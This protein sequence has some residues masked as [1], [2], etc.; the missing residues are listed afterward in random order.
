MKHNVSEMFMVPT[1]NI[2]DDLDYIK[3]I[4][5]EDMLSL[6]VHS[7]QNYSKS[8]KLARKVPISFAKPRN[9]IVSGMG[10]SAIG[11]ELLKDW[12]RDRA[13]VA[14]EVCR[15]YSL[16]AYANKETLVFVNSYSGETEET[17]SV[18]LDAV[19][20]NCKIV[21]VSS[22]GKLLEFAERLSL[23]YIRVPSDMPPRAALPF[24]FVPL[25]IV[26]QK[27]GF[28]SKVEKELSDATDVVEQI[29]EVNSPQRSCIENFSKTLASEICG[30]IPVIYGFG[31]YRGVGQ[32][33]KQQFN[34]NS[35]I[36]AKWE[37]FSELN[38]NEIVGWEEAD[39]F[40]RCF[41]IMF[42]RDD[43]ERPEIKLRIETSKE[44]IPEQVKTFEVW[45]KG[46]N[47]LSKM[48][49]VV[50][51]GDFT[52]IYI[53][54]LRGVDPTPVGTISTLKQKLAQGNTRSKT[55]HDLEKISRK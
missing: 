30:T 2:L 6:C 32:R 54:L 51:I 28:V 48:L 10:G 47:T 3:R 55:L 16:P 1:Q 38:H 46:T 49:S 15:D 43:K 13:R 37:Y 19:K 31:V 44:I 14:I 39:E 36:P 23:P 18:L 41:S 7:A 45:S 4:D 27:L 11:G 50:C 40:L 22:G 29:I 33:F 24:M 42:I 34:E 8:M 21:C 53:A 35:K 12:A 26:C 20:R 25:I 5:K 17:L 9:I 52:S